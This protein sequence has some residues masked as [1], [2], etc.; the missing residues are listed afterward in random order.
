MNEQLRGRKAAISVV[1][2]LLVGTLGA[3]RSAAPS[4]SAARETAIFDGSTLNGW[5]QRGGRA[6]FGVEN[7]SIVGRSV[8]NQPNSFL[9]TQ[10]TFRDFELSLDF[11]VDALLNSGIQIRS[12]SNP[13][14]QGGRV[15]G[16]QV[17][18]DPSERA[19]TA[20]IYDEGR[21]GWLRDLKENPAARAAFRPGDWN[22]LRIR[23]VGPH[24]QTWLNDVPAADLVDS[25]TPEG[26]I[27]LQVHD[28]G[29]RKEPLEVRWRNIKLVEIAAADSPGK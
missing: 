5:V 11:K 17:E 21:R 10:R 6:S 19:W 27:G 28:V 9:C 12:E 14:R 8:P 3:C 1:L 22:H 24:I 2:A 25:M 26:F 29:Q 16:Y 15:F 23:A 7:A 4:N 13:E 20:G 18:I